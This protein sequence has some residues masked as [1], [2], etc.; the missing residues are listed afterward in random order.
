[1]TVEVVA[2]RLEL[3]HKLVPTALILAALVNPANPN[4]EPLSRYLQAGARTLGLQLHV[5]HAS[6][7]R[8]FDTVFAT[9]VQLS[10]GGW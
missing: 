4:A 2:K 8:D 3:L 6:N 7:E 5:L 10:A 1:L 9:L